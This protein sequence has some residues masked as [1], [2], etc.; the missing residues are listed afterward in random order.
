MIIELFGPPG[1]GKTTFA[2][3]LAAQIRERGQAAEL[4]LSYRPAEQLGCRASEALG[5]H[6][7]H[8]AD[9]VRRVTR[10]I[11]ELFSMAIHSSAISQQICIAADLLNILPQRSTISFI[12]MNQYIIRLS[13]SWFRAS[14]S[15]DFVL[16][17]Q[18]FVQ[19]I[20]SLAFS[21]GTKDVELMR[22]AL[23]VAP[24]ADLLIHVDAPTDVLETRLRK[25]QG[26]QGR[27]ERLLEPDLKKNL[28]MK[29]IAEHLNRLLRERGRLVARVEYVDEH[30]LPKAARE[31]ARQLTT[32]SRPPGEHP[33]MRG[34][35]RPTLFNGLTKERH[36][37][38]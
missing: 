38:G 16:F 26:R 33:P 21:S 31:I 15:S 34:T 32:I 6:L 30:S 11:I 9:M 17:D 5:H 10:P 14:A 7:Q 22:R 29:G 28:E 24:A 13:G 12:R 4:V 8:V 37:H 2:N 20:C 19:A 27:L 3:L 1:S 36:P 23:D 18:A 25:R 35:A